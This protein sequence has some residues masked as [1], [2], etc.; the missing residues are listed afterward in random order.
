MN[1]P[2][3]QLNGV[4]FITGLLLVP[5]RFFLMMLPPFNLAEMILFAAAATI[6]A[7]CFGV[8]PSW[9][10]VLLFL[11]VLILVLFIVVSWLGMSNL[12]QG[13]G[14]GHVVSLV[15]IPLATLAGAH[16]GHNPPGESLK[17]RL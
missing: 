10:V 13:I 1:R 12:R 17:I 15:L 16:Y 4:A 9:W 11:P 6:I 7:S 2:V 3:W 14:V 5:V 8:R